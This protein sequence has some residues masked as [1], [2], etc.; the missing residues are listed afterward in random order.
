MTERFRFRLTVAAAAVA[1]AAVLPGIAL[2]GSH[3]GRVELP[4]QAREVRP[5][6]FF[7]GTATDNGRVV[8][9]YAIVHPR[10]NA[11]RPDGAGN[12]KGNGNGGGSDCY[13]FLANGAKW[14]AA[15]AFVVNGTNVRGLDAGTVAGLIDTGIGR[16]EVAIL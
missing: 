10:R 16:W 8:E 2:A 12:G 6:V 5:D 7:L 4:P 14:R 15:E 3:A 1:L 9:G 13:A 11:A